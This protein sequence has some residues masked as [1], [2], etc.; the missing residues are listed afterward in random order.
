MSKLPA[1]MHVASRWLSPIAI[2]LLVL[3]VQGLLIGAYFYLVSIGRFNAEPDEIALL[4]TYSVLTMIL[5]III[6]IMRHHSIQ[7]ENR[8]RQRLLDV[9]DAVPDPSA[10][11]D[12]KGRYVLW[13]KAAEQYHGIKAPH[14]LGKTPYEIFPPAVARS[15]LELDA[16]CVA[17]NQT[18]VKRINLPPLYG[19]G[20]RVAAIRVAPVHTVDDRSNVRGVVTIL[21]DITEAELE[22]SQLR[23]TASQLKV[24]LDASGFGSWE[25]VLE[26][27]T[28]AFGEG[29][30]KLMR[31]QG[32]HF[33]QD[34]NIRERLHPED[35][36]RVKEA[37]IASIAQQGSFDINYRIKCFDG[38][39]RNFRS[40]GEVSKH[41]DGKTHFAGLLCPLDGGS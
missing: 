3:L 9:I 24:A 2:V 31:Y 18:V 38:V 16:E 17:Q 25:W 14:V 13:N 22:A 40:S 35:Y 21:H 36:K 11:R 7:R 27:N 30:Q 6:A 33:L 5:A 29:Y 26:D 23:S 28:A 4:V 8:V 37:V 41:A 19:K 32:K 10:V 12:A 20:H 1:G 34:F 15:I 39:Y